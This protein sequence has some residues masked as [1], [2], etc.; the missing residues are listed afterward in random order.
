M[1]RLGER[2]GERL[3]R[4]WVCTRGNG[5]RDGF[6]DI[7][8]NKRILF[9]KQDYYRCVCQFVNLIVALVGV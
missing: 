8:Q 9:F 3:R 6:V 1:T 4:C 5:E 7:F 2:G